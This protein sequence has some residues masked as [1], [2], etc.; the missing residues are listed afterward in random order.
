MEANEWV[1][2]FSPK[3]DSH[4]FLAAP[5]IEEQQSPDEVQTYQVAGQVVEAW[6]NGADT[7]EITA[8]DLYE[9][10]IKGL[11]AKIL[12]ATF[13]SDTYKK[14]V[15]VYKESYENLSIELDAARQSLDVL[16]ADIMPVTQRPLF[17][18][19]DLRD[20]K[21]EY[22]SARRTIADLE[23]QLSN[24]V[25]ER[26][27]LELKLIAE[28]RAISSLKSELVDAKAKAVTELLSVQVSAAKELDTLKTIH[29]NQLATVN[30]HHKDAIKSA[31]QE[32][33]SLSGKL[34]KAERELEVST[35]DLKKLKAI[36]S[37]NKSDKEKTLEVMRK[38]V[39]TLNA[40]E[41]ELC[42]L[43]KDRRYLTMMVDCL[44]HEDIFTADEGS[45]SIFSYLTLNV[46]SVEDDFVVDE[47]F[48]IALWMGR[49]GFS[50]VLGVSAINANGD[51]DLVM[52]SSPKV[53]KRAL[54]EVCPP[55]KHHAE[56][57]RRIS[58]FDAK[59][60][61]AALVRS[62]HIVSELAIRGEFEENAKLT[63]KDLIA[64]SRK[65]VE[66]RNASVLSNKTKA[67][68]KRKKR[69]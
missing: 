21:R 34:K 52:P 9:S 48:P 28:G 18:P 16:S 24:V 14:R 40:M 58:A 30:G 66:G 6:F 15:E 20:L 45:V 19:Q 49:N 41:N 43:R 3:P 1:A 26:Q 27:N 25:T 63:N 44:I 31:N 37:S 11:K 42:V 69:G 13:L 8:F 7:A 5:E 46:S 59:A 33:L 29:D 12:S 54:A 22:E 56:I 4:N 38:S 53:S 17:V 61:D 10:V 36:V 50:C 2:R 35:A 65:Y 47:A 62:R 55:A 32:A 68:N 23:S 64:T 39:G 51:R 57:V 67:S 60:C